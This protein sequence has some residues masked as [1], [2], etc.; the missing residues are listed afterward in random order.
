VLLL[1]A[2][3][4]R[5]RLRSWMRAEDVV[6]KVAPAGDLTAALDPA[7][8]PELVVAEFGSGEALRELRVCES[9][10]SSTNFLPI[11][12]EEAHASIGPLSGGNTSS[13]CT[14][15]RLIRSLAT[16][17]DY[18]AARA[19]L[20]APS[21]EQ[22]VRAAV[23]P[24]VAVLALGALA[25]ELLR[26]LGGK[27]PATRDAVLHADAVA[28]TVQRCRLLPVPGCPTCR[29]R[30]GWAEP[31]RDPEATGLGLAVFDPEAAIY[32]PVEDVRLEHLPPWEPQI[33]IVS[34]TLA[35]EVS[36]GGV[37]L[38]RQR[39]VFGCGLDLDSA[40][41]AA[42]G[43]A[44]ERCAGAQPERQRKRG[45]APQWPLQERVPV[46]GVEELRRLGPGYRRGWEHLTDWVQ[47]RH[48]H[49]ADAGAVP[50]QLVYTPYHPPAGEALVWE[51]VTTGLAAARSRDSAVLS[52]LLEV[53]ERDAL[54]CAWALRRPARRLRLEDAFGPQQ[55]AVCSRVLRGGLRL[56]LGLLPTDL[57]LPVVVA[58]LASDDG[59]VYCSFGSAAA[60]T[61]DQASLK[62]TM[63]AALVRHTLILRLSL[64]GPPPV[65]QHP[66]AAD[67]ADFQ[68]H[69]LAWTAPVATPRT[70]WLFAG[71]GGTF[72]AAAADLPDAA[73]RVEAAGYEP[74]VADLMPPPFATG[75]AAVRVVVPGLQPLNPG[76]H[77]VMTDS[78]R[79]RAV[80][81]AWQVD[82][83]PASLNHDVHPWC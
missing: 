38:L 15:C 76:R 25:A 82:S 48:W 17:R 1:G 2:E 51:P 79:L 6:L 31:R 19:D 29:R 70:D 21:Q 32:G 61:V 9:L 35:R 66:A 18:N 52:G 46:W 10:P 3:L 68:E 64:A 23:P 74:L 33:R 4:T 27:P 28:G 73:G 63:E 83:D 67:P 13:A 43:E 11:T 55:E 44:V 72:A 77:R 26:I 22:R 7:A 75:W 54:A 41:G 56:S 42:M 60:L 47:M 34:A 12:L 30:R 16:A 5:G 59:P 49:G 20:R 39:R 45:A 81:A 71:D 65:P 80:A 53:V 58:R 50:A 62:A 8:P 36:S 40:A 37:D 24:P 57:G 69:G 78:P 14:R